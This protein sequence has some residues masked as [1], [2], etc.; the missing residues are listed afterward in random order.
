MATLFLVIS[1]GFQPDQ[2]SICT[3]KISYIFPAEI[4]LINPKYSHENPAL[5]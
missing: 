1:F 5:Q 3:A 4:L 2:W